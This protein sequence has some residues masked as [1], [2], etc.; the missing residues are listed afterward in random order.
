M[1]CKRVGLHILSGEHPEQFGPPGDIHPYG[2]TEIQGSMRVSPKSWLALG[3]SRQDLWLSQQEH[4]TYEQ[5]SGRDSL[6]GRCLRWSQHHAP[7]GHPYS[8]KRYFGV[9]NLRQPFFFLS[10]P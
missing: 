8:A 5:A 1:T 3:E 2:R 6:S 10:F 9:Q 4:V 7:C